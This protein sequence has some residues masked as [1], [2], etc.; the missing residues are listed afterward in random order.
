MRSASGAFSSTARIPGL[1][2]GRTERKFFADLTRDGAVF[3]NEIIDFF[4]FGIEKRVPSGN[5]RV[6]SSGFIPAANC[7]I[8]AISSKLSTVSRSTK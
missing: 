8:D 2:I 3:S 4:H 5:M 7:P 1:L 6:A